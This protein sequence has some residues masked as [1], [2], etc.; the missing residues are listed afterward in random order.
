M[1]IN[2]NKY[3]A[4]LFT[5]AH[6]G[7]Y[8]DSPEIILKNTESALRDMFKQL[9]NLSSFQIRMCKINSKSFNVPW[10]DTKLL[11]ETIVLDDH[12]TSSTQKTV[13][14]IDLV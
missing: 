8:K 6:Y 12:D 14:I 13:Y 5:S 10:K 11:L 9:S 2:T 7:K 3:I 4:C 1:M